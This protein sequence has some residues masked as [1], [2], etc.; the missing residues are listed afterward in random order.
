MNM[1]TWEYKVIEGMP[2]Q[3]ETFVDRLNLFG[4]EGWELVSVTT[5]GERPIKFKAF[6]KRPKAEVRS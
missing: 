4:Q 1:T 6:F 5:E 2:Y 3:L